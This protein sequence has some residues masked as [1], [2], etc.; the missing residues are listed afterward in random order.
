MF[1]K[2]T[3]VTLFVSFVA[4]STSGL[5]MFVIE[6]PSFTIQ[7][8]PVHKLFGL[9][10]ILSEI[11]HLSFNYRTLLGY[12]ETKTVAIYGGAA[13]AVLILLYGVE[14]NNGVPEAIAT[15]MDTLAAK[16]ELQE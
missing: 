15:P 14:M 12:L 2:I 10:L 13:V 6:K 4:K 3:A 7:M 9:L 11:A 5:I 1:R 16:A 8:H